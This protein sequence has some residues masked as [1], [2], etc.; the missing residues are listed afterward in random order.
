MRDRSIA[1]TACYEALMFR[2]QNFAGFYTIRSEYDYTRSTQLV[3]GIG[4]DD[5]AVGVQ[6][7]R[8]PLLIQEDGVALEPCRGVISV[9]DKA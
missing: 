2:A 3:K 1:R 6:P 7:S 9:M 8:V 4:K 5:S